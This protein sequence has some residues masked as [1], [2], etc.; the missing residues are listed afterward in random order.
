MLARNTF[1]LLLLLLRLLL[2]LLLLLLLRFLLLLQALVDLSPLQNCP[3]LF[4]VLLLTSPV[5]HA[6]VLQIFLY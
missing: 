6:H 4:S 2:L 5:P 3:P 1:L